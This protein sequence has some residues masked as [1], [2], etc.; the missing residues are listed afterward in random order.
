MRIK[1]INTY[2]LIMENLYFSL[3]E[4][5][6][7]LYNTLLED[8]EYICNEMC[9]DLK[10]SLIESFKNLEPNL[11]NNQKEYIYENMRNIHNTFYNL[12][13]KDIREKLSKLYESIDSSSK[14]IYMEFDYNDDLNYI[15][16]SYISLNQRIMNVNKELYRKEYMILTEQIN[17]DFIN[18]YN[19][20]IEYLSEGLIGKISEFLGRIKNGFGNK[21]NKILNRDKKWLVSNKKN[22]L[23][24]D[25]S[26]VELE[27]VSDYNITFEGLMQRHNIFDKNFINSNNKD[28]LPDLLRRFEDKKG[29]IK[30]GLDNYFRTGSSKKE[31]GMRKV[32]GDDAKT[33]VENMIDYCENFLAGK[34]FLDEKI[35]N[36]TKSLSDLGVK[37][38][39]DYSMLFGYEYNPYKYITLEANGD[40]N[41][42]F[43]EDNDGDFD[44]DEQPEEKNN[45]NEIKENGRGIR[46]RQVGIA[47]LLT[48][49]E[50]RYFDYI[51][52]L[53]G[54][55]E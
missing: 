34:K 32:S 23:N 43:D 52:I 13:I 29:D 1:N 33:A 30:N 54:L 22:L 18:V 9:K 50:E 7:T 14:S 53:K 36:I 55:V 6:K 49:T 26:N 10:N 37:E 16:E 35:D 47:V 21:H 15:Y 5:N 48:V 27:V 12:E 39:S 28:K 41:I 42:E 44:E 38:T 51:K 40:F 3:N 20:N 2:E 4:I 46:D 8:N 45:M 17:E 11:L 25:Y 31:I 19:K 24:M